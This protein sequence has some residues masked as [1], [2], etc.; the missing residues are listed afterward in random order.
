[1]R[2]C[3]NLGAMRFGQVG[4]AALALVLVGCD[5]DA[6]N[7]RKVIRERHAERVKEIIAEDMAR[8]REGIADAAQRLAPGF[9]VEDPAERERQMR[10]A[11]TYVQ[12]PPRGI[13]EFI[14]SPMSFLAAIGKDGKVIARDVP[15]EEDRMKGEDFGERYDVVRRA[16]SE[17]LAG[18]GLGEFPSQEEGGKSSWSMLF[19]HPVKRHGEVLGAVVAGIPLWRMS[20]RLSRQIQAENVDEEGV[21]LWVYAYKG[22]ELHHFGTPPDLDTVVPDAQTRRTGLERSPGGFT[23]EVQQFG[24]WY[25]WGVLPTTRIGDDVGMVIF[26]SDPM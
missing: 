10:I 11:L 25:A 19:V 16:L 15:A 4:L 8:H 2:T 12:E 13:P 22:D 23:G 3:C 17:G 1:M 7:A 26:R 18:Y 5:G 20:Q 21:I 14:A 9:A 6:A 24:R